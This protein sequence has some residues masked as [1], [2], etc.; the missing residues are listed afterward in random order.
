[1]V[2]RYVDGVAGREVLD[3]GVTAQRETLI[4]RAADPYWRDAD[5]TVQTVEIADR[6]FLSVAGSAWLPWQL[7]SGD[8]LGAFQVTN[9]GD[10][11]SWPTWAIHGPGEHPR[12]VNETTG[13]RIDLGVVLDAGDVVEIDTRPGAKTVVGPDGETL[14]PAMADDSTLWPLRRGG[15]R[16]VLELDNAE[17]GVSNV[18]LAYRRQWLTV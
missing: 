18:R 1:M 5:E 13:E 3:A 11:D 4:F 16:V 14:W 6:A 10:R 17:A 7:V 12:I 9:D 2:C 8:A 15:Q